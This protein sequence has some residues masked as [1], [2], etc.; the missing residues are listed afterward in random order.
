MINKI[1]VLL[2]SLFFI[3]L[4]S[5]LCLYCIL[6]YFW[7]SLSIYVY[8]VCYSVD[9]M[10]SYFVFLFCVVFSLFFFICDMHIMPLSSVYIMYIFLHIMHIYCLDPCVIL[11][12]CSAPFPFYFLCLSYVVYIFIL[13]GCIMV[14]ICFCLSVI[15][16][17]VYSI[18]SLFESCSEL[19]R[20]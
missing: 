13:S 16:L 5:I 17:Y 8:I 11:C 6:P 3:C 14:A 19:I 15:S 9:C 10:V 12:C 1:R 2:P 18:E 4:E 7:L 20:S